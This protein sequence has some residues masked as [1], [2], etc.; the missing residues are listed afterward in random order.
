MIASLEGLAG[1]PRPRP[2]YPAEA[3]LWGKPT[4]INN[5]E[6]WYNLPVILNMGPTWYCRTGTETVPAPRSSRWSAR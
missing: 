3:G 5:V 2:P 1:R 4:N 6:T